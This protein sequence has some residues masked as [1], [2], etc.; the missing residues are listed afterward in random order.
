[1]VLSETYWKNDELLYP[2][3][4]ATSADQVHLSSNMNVI[5]ARSRE[6]IVTHAKHR[7]TR[8][9]TQGNGAAAVSKH[10]CQS[11]FVQRPPIKSH[12]A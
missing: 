4:G 12:L 3:G 6:P 8:G 7:Y 1:M 11:G 2:S 5:L 10:A 9:E